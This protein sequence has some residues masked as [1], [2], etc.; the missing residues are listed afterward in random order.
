[1]L[2]SLI[3]DAVRLIRENG[4]RG[5]SYY[6]H[7]GDGSH[8]YHYNLETATSIYFRCVMY[9]KLRCSGRAIY[10]IGGTFRHSKPHNHPPDPDFVGQRHFR[11][12]V[13]ERCGDAQYVGYQDIVDEARRDQR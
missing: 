2:L 13:L 8:A 4:F 3:G 10:R 12:N 11:E 6:Y 5:N 7:L 9:D 1:M